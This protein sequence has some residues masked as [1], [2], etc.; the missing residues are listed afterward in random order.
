MKTRFT[1]ALILGFTLAIAAIGDVPNTIQYQGRLLD[2]QGNALNT[3]VTVGVAVFASDAGG[4]A[5]YV[6]HVGSVPVHNGVVAFPFGG[7]TL[8]ASLSGP[9]A[10]L[11]VTIDGTPLNPRQ[12]LLSVPYAVVADGVRPGAITSEMLADGAVSPEKMALPFQAGVIDFS[13]I[14]SWRAAET[15]VVFESA[16][17]GPPT[18]MAT[19]EASRT[20]PQGYSFLVTNITAEGFGLSA[21]FPTFSYDLTPRVYSGFGLLAGQPCYAFSQYDSSIGE[22]VLSFIRREN[23]SGSNWLAPVAIEEFAP[24]GAS[25]SYIR[26]VAVAEVDGRPAVAYLMTYS[27]SGAKRAIGYT[28]GNADG[29]NWPGSRNIVVM[30]P[31]DSY[32][33][34]LADING[35]PAIAYANSGAE[36]QFVYSQ[37]V[38]GTQWS[39][40]VSAVT[41]VRTGTYGY[42]A[43]YYFAN[44]GPKLSEFGGG[45]CFAYPT[46]SNEIAW[47]YGSAEGVFWSSPVIV[48]TNVLASQLS[49]APPSVASVDGVPALSYLDPQT[50]GMQLKY[51]RA[52]SPNGSAWGPAAVVPSSLSDNGSPV[53]AQYRTSIGVVGGMPSIL[54]GLGSGLVAHV[55]ARDT[56]GSTWNI[57]EKLIDGGA[58]LKLTGVGAPVGDAPLSEFTLHGL[59]NGFIRRVPRDAQGVRLNWIAIKP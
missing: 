32:S 14:S 55:Q 47:V 7:S 51:V 15:N 54:Y 3:N 9:E 49:G 21:S 22:H 28:V 58:D 50:S 17:S 1:G 2:A 45:P 33:I 34:S 30:L 5:G 4:V 43:P 48:D 29:S 16:F 36:I 6:E 26:Q 40:P 19:W 38:E 25:G 37:N 46:S 35:R 10:W 12:R 11:E 52:Q 56:Q 27:L 13:G 44:E 24:A 41:N 18:V 39:S 42:T 53:S 8:A 57:P 31:S 59:P 20:F 23:N